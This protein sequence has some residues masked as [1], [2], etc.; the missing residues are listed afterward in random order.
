MIHSGRL[1]FR[2]HLENLFQ[3]WFADTFIVEA[4]A[5]GEDA[6]TWITLSTAVEL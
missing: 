2:V 1:I 6:L 5:P 4:L 3:V